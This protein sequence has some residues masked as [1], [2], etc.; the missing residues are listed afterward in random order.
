[1]GGLAEVVIVA[2]ANAL[3]FTSMIERRILPFIRFE[4]HARHLCHHGES[5]DGLS[6]FAFLEILR[7]SGKYSLVTGSHIFD[8]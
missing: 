7:G 1:M 4:V 8:C 2:S 5:A 6:E 3:M